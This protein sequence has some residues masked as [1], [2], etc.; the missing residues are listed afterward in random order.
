MHISYNPQ[1]DIIKIIE[2]LKEFEERIS[3]LEVTILGLQ[4]TKIKP[5]S[6]EQSNGGTSVSN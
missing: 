6:E 5:P 2:K 4:E 1:P 3:E